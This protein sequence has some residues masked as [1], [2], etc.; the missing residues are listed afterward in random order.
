MSYEAI[1]ILMFAGMV[2][3]ML[4]GQR[5][6]AMIGAVAAASARI[7]L[8]PFQIGN[9]ILILRGNPEFIGKGNIVSGKCPACFGAAQSP[10]F[11]QHGTVWKTI[12]GVADV[13]R[14]PVLQR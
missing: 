5:V 6:F 3:L 14:G 4:T 7:V 9:G 11:G 10:A 8:C 2:L 1:A 12:G 13:G